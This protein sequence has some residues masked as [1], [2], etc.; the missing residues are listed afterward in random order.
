MIPSILE[1]ISLLL[2]A[3]VLRPLPIDVWKAGSYGAL[4]SDIGKEILN[5]VPRSGSLVKAIAP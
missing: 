2:K 5:V 3:A 1:S 4:V